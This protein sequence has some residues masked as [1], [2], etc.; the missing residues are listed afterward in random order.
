MRRH[1]LAVC[2]ALLAALFVAASANAMQIH[3]QVRLPDGELAKV[4]VDV[5]P[6]DSDQ[7]GVAN[8]NDNCPHVA[9]SASYSGCVPPP[10]TPTLS[11]SSATATAS[12]TSSAGGCGGTTPYEGGGS[13]WAIPYYIVECES[14][15]SYTASNPSGATGAYQLMIGGG[16]DPASQDAAAAALWN[17]G[18]G[19][20]NWTCAN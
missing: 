2:A 7:D 12:A 10:P 14:G 17:G 11:S 1:V 6:P 13:C 15:G 20:S 16:G 19:A 8:A 18:A 3:K 9:G 5:P 4:A